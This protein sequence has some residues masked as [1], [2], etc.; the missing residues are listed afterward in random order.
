MTQEQFDN[1]RFSVNTQV[2]NEGNWYK[3][4]EVNFGEGYIGVDSG[5]YLPIRD[6]TDIREGSEL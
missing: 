3:V 2:K 6:Y 4:T 1:Y 5:Y